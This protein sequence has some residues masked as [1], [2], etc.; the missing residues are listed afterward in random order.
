MTHKGNKCSLCDKWTEYFG[1]HAIG[2]NA[3]CKGHPMADYRSV[4]QVPVYE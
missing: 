2:T 4:K 1:A 3:F